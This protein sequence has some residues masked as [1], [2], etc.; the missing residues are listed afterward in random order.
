VARDKNSFVKVA[1]DKNSF[2]KVARD[3]NSFVK[4]A[5]DKNSFVK[6]GESLCFCFTST[7]AAFQRLLTDVCALCARGGWQ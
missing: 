1:R 2:V 3:K 7:A 5:R 4:V 6:V